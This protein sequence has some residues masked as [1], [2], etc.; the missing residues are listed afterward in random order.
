LKIGIGRHETEE[1]AT[2]GSRQAELFPAGGQ[3]IGIEVSPNCRSGLRCSARPAAEVDCFD[4]KN[5][6]I[7][8]LRFIYRENGMYF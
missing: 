1:Q 6:N 7:G 8:R 4:L 5:E 2:A 3:A